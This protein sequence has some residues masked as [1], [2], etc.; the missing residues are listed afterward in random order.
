MTVHYT[1]GEG[2]V[3]FDQKIIFF[4]IFTKPGFFFLFEKKLFYWK[5]RIVLRFS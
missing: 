2:M 5:K 3:S 4:L 1:W